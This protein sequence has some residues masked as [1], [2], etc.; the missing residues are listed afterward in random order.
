MIKKAAMAITTE[1]MLSP[2][3]LKLRRFPFLDR[4][5]HITI[6]QRRDGRKLIFGAGRNDCLWRKADIET[7]RELLAKV[8]TNQ[9]VL[10]EGCFPPSADFNREVRA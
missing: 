1:R 2:L 4:L 5:H 6:P 7:K 9:Q 3:R 8:D 10:A